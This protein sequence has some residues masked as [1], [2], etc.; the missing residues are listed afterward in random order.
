MQ[1]C[2]NCNTEIEDNLD[3]CWNCCYS[4][5][6]NRVIDIEKESDNEQVKS[7]QVIKKAGDVKTVKIIIFIIA[8]LVSVAIA[9]VGALSGNNYP[10][11]GILL[12]PIAYKIIFNKW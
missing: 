11:M 7:S 3:I 6:E 10:W 2:P 4:L 9:V 1:R 12:I 5:T 8:C